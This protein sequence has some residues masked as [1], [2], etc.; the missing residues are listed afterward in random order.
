MPK[1]LMCQAIR[2]LVGLLSYWVESE[3]SFELYDMGTSWNFLVLF[4]FF[5]LVPLSRERISILSKVFGRD[6][7]LAHQEIRVMAPGS[8]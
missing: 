7:G 4:T 3:L 8:V 2:G 6:T 1:V 5:P